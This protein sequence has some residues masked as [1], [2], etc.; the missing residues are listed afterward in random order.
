MNAC[1]DYEEFL[2]KWY[3]MNL[4]DFTKTYSLK[5]I[6]DLKLPEALQKNNLVRTGIILGATSS[7]S[8][9]NKDFFVMGGP[10]IADCYENFTLESIAEISNLLNTAKTL[11]K[12][13]I[14]FLGVK[15]EEIRTNKNW[16][17]RGDDFEG[18][19]N[20]IAKILKN[21]NFLIVRSD[22]QDIEKI[23]QKFLALLD[24]EITKEQLFNLYN[25][26][27]TR[28]YSEDKAK[29]S[30]DYSLHKRFI[31]TYFPEFVKEITNSTKAIPLLACENLQQIKALKQAQIIS[32]RIGNTGAIPEQLIHLP[33]PNL[34]GDNRMYRSNNENKIFISD[35]AK[36][37]ETLLQKSPENVFFY[38]SNIWPKE[39]LDKQIENKADFTQFFSGLQK[40]LGVNQNEQ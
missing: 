12:K 38:Y 32:K 2:K 36:K 3:W 20:K 39:L 21:D 37:I 29:C 34:K 5:K 40:K 11:N 26:G 23:S 35:N 24:I 7:L 15:E 14:V 13:A 27:K 10:C 9:L 1:F 6:E 28:P 25:V 22:N 19:I 4:N 30:F 8:F 31:V 16:K 17:K 18:L 33:F